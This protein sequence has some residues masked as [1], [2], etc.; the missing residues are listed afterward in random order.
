MRSDFVTG[1]VNRDFW[2]CGSLAGF[3]AGGAALCELQSA[4]FVAEFVILK[5]QISWQAQRLV[6][7]AVQISWEAQ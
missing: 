7:L 3:V 4:Y 2:T 6:N 5:V 1:A